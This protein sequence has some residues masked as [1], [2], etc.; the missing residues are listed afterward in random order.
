MEK[1]LKSKLLEFQILE[2]RLK[3]L[4]SRRNIILAKIR[5]IEETL[6]CIDEI[7]RSGK[8]EILLSIGSNVYA[9]GN[10]KKEEKIL[11][12]LGA[13]IVVEKRFEEAKNFLDKKL[14]ILESGLNSIEN[15]MVNLSGRLNRLGEEIRK[16]VGEAG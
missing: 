4:E 9:R 10:L 3:V 12:E 14:K 8:R 5:E 13:G 11:V 15:E 7:E 16:K 6:N 2:N 1:D